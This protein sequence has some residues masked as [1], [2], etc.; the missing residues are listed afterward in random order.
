V[1]AQYRGPIRVAVVGVAALGY[2]AVDHPTGGTALGFVLVTGLVVLLVEVLATEA[3]A[4]PADE[5]AD[6]LTSSG[7]H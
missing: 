6:G 2:L 7:S 5:P 4:E 1:L 3:P